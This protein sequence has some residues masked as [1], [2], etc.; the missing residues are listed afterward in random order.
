[1][2]NRQ[3]AWQCETSVSHCQARWGSQMKRRKALSWWC[4]CFID[5]EALLCSCKQE[6]KK[7]KTGKNGMMIGKCVMAHLPIIIPLFGFS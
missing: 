2:L 1:M 6:C 5:A 3:I 7:S 4:S